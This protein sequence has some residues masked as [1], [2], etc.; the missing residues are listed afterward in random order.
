MHC[1]KHDG[2]NEKIKF[3]QENHVSRLNNRKRDENP[4][5]PPLQLIL[6]ELTS[7]LGKLEMTLNSSG[8][9]PFAVAKLSRIYE[10]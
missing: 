5:K 10:K 1:L 3:E 8:E 4:P 7:L 9:K 2:L 6:V